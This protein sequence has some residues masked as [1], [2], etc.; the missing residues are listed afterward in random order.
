MQPNKVK[1][2]ITGT[3]LVIFTFIL[4]LNAS[5]ASDDES[6]D[7]G[8]R[9][10]K[11]LDAK[12]TKLFGVKKPIKESF[13][14]TLERAPGQAA[15]DLIILA[16]GLKAEILTRNAADKADMFALW[17][18]DKTASYLIFCIE[19]SRELIGTLPSGINKY[20]PSVQRI[21][22]NTG[23]VETILR[24]MN[25]CD[26]IRRTPWNTVLVTEE[27]DD[28]AAYEIIDPLTITNNSVLD[29]TTGEIISADGNPST[30]IVKRDSLPT[31]AW[32]GLTVLSSGVVIAGDELRPGSAAPDVDGGALF[33]FVPAVANNGTPIADLSESPLVAGSVFALQVS[34]VNSKQQFGQGCE[35]G[36]GA[37]VP[38]NAATARIDADANGATGYYR[39]EDLHQDP[40]YQGEG[41]RF[42]WTNTG[43]KG[44]SNYGEIIC[45]IDSDPLVADINTRTVIVNRFLEG[46]PDMNQPDNLAFQPKTG[47]VYVIED[48]P[49]GDVFACLPDGA[50]RDIKSDGC[51]KI[52]SLKD[53][54]AEP[55]GFEFTGDGK[56]AFV[57][58]QHSNDDLMPL[59][60][61]FRTDDIV[62]ITGFKIKKSFGKNKEE[63]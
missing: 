16:K 17:P 38:V 37:W 32:E 26:G 60:D 53:P 21:N 35:I 3:S 1:L 7:F 11:L 51:V 6:R 49:N 52:L 5:F 14:G 39:P 43:N 36:N 45:G 47:N 62:K 61:E 30:N 46:D 22:A 2:L 15:Q 59:F 44:A 8:K 29:R 25:R 50:D 54:S 34:C 28:G 19:G 40:V 27:T 55:T 18:D 31:M 42:C 48:N 56:T 23:E 24:G 57:S 33:K 63:D 12:S 4:Q 10:E 13:N 58:I 9:V 41:V 20:N